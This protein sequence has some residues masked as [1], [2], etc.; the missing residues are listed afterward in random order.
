MK[1]L[2]L[3]DKTRRAAALEGPGRMRDGL[4]QCTDSYTSV[5]F[6]GPADPCVA[7]PDSVM[8]EDWGCWVLLGR[9][10]VPNFF[11]KKS[12]FVSYE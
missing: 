2:T 10:V 1:S 7:K 12:N 3:E 8:V 4:P 11:F 9:R 6:A 5:T